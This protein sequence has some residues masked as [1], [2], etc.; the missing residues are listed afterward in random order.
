VVVDGVPHG[1][2]VKLGMALAAFRTAR[3]VAA[4]HEAKLFL[5]WHLANLVYA[6]A[7]SLTDLSMA[8]WDLYDPYEVSR[9]HCYI[10]GGN[11]HFVRAFT[12]GI[13]NVPRIQYGGDGLRVHGDKMAFCGDMVL[14]T[15]SLGMLLLW[16]TRHWDPSILSAL[17]VIVAWGQATL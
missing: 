3:G 2:E 16:I 7:A 1:V 15:V 12:N 14:C 10:P 6:I 9:D 13:L 4:K 5:D 8:L 17:F 11:S